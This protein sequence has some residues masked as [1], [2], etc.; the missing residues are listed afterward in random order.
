M[1]GLIALRGFESRPLRQIR[2]CTDLGTSHGRSSRG[3]SDIHTKQNVELMAHWVALS[4]Y[5][6]RDRWAAWIA[7]SQPASSG[8]AMKSGKHVGANGPGVGITG[9][10][11]VA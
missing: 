10:Q 9:L 7:A 1:R 6:M 4:Q 11:P 5:A 3:T 2:V 8:R